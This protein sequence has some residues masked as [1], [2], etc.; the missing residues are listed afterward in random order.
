M[1]DDPKPI[2]DLPVD[3]QPNDGE[4]PDRARTFQVGFNHWQQVL[5]DEPEPSTSNGKKRKK[6]QPARKTPAPKFENYNPK[7]P[8]KF[9]IES[10]EVHFAIFRSGLFRSCNKR[11]DGVDVSLRKAWYDNT[12]E[13][14]GFIHGSRHHKATKMGIDDNNSFQEFMGLTQ[15]VPATTVMG[16]KIYHENPKLTSNFQRN[17]EI[18]RQSNAPKVPSS[19]SEAHPESDDS[20][21]VSKPIFP[22]LICHLS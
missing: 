16:F 2:P 8:H 19:D 9:V 18:A 20:A 17:L 11:L 15:S 10:P 12:I 13:I 22:R 5:P 21:G 3:L 6:A 14:Q 7:F 1:F 4:T